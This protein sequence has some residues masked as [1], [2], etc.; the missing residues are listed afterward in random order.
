[1]QNQFVNEE[2]KDK[3]RINLINVKSDKYNELIKSNNTYDL[4]ICTHS[5]SEFDINT[6]K[7]YIDDILI[8]K[9]KYLLY[10]YHHFAPNSKELM[11]FKVSLLEQ[12]FSKISSALSEN[13]NVSNIIY[14][15]KKFL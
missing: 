1:M 8:K 11:D 4:T 3:L 15:N 6:F 10:C 9:T 5:L 13:N 7:K 2:I 12:H 14:I